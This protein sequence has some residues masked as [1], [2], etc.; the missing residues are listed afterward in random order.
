ML[1]FRTWNNKKR[2]WVKGVLLSGSGENIVMGRGFSV[3]CKPNTHTISFA[4]GRQDKNGV[5]VFE[6]DI[7]INNVIVGNIFENPELRSA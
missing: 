1:K 3:R 2:K 7:E 4:K 6:G 5:D